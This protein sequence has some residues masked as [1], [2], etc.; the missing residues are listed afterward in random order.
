LRA[1]RLAKAQSKPSVSRRRGR[2]AP[3]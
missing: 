2:V 3:K 1:A